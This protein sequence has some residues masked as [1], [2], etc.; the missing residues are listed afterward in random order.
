[1]T[2]L[3]LSALESVVVSQNIAFTGVISIAIR[4]SRSVDARIPCG[5]ISE[6]DR[7]L[8]PAATPSTIV[9]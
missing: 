6:Q 5:R 4:M 8:V 2:L 7:W 9:A 1:M 3:S